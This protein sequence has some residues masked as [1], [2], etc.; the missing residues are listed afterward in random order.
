MDKALKP[1]TNYRIHMMVLVC[2]ALIINYIDRVNFSV[3]TPT[4]MELFNITAAQIGLMGSAFFIP[5]M[6]MM[7][8]TGYL[9]N[10]VGP[11]K[12]L[13]GSLF[14]WGL[15]TMGTAL[16][17]NVWTFLTTRVLMGLFEA[18]GF[19]SAS[20]VV[21][22]WI[23][24]QERTVASGAFD[25]CARIG[26]AFAPPLVVWII[27]TLGWQM[28]FVITG[29]C[30]VLFA[31]VWMAMYHEPDDHPK[32]SESELAYIRQHEVKDESGQIVSKPIP[33][34]H[35][36]FYPALVKASI[37]YGLYLYV[38]NM[39]TTWM[40]SFFV[41][42]RGFSLKSMGHA[43]MVPYICAVVL[44]LIGAVL[45]D[46]WMRRG[47]KISTLRRTGM[48]I[49]LVGSAIF[50]FLTI[51][52][53]TPF[54]IVFFLSAFAGISGLG[55]GN[56][57]AIPSDLAP[58]GQAGGVSG[59]YA[60]GGA[61]GGFFAPM[62]TGFIIDS[63]FGY[64]GAFVVASLVALAGAAFYVFNNYERMEPRKADLA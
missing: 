44:E 53:T 46:R 29:G 61:I 37:G 4:I 6:L 30:A 58:Y 3:A 22:V 26:T 17:S 42:A 11:K 2:I 49:S 51:Q 38:W 10:K 47:A 5:Y 62:V 54:W 13:G 19:P 7:L 57:Q 41:V 64:D 39:F 34:K 55:A 32:V 1:D 23:P 59:F 9:L 27:L 18:P 31:F 16:A 45:F 33:M 60:L 56:V 20:R 40:P 14:F 8:P 21:A 48:A 36:I 50:I 24:E 63:R 52:A 43:A 35:L 12:L 28:S 25:C 15:S